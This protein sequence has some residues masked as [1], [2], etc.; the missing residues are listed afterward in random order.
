MITV[1]VSAVA[2]LP[3]PSNAVPLPGYLDFCVSG[4]GKLYHA[5]ATLVINVNGSSFSVPAN[6]GSGGCMR[7]IHTH[8]VDGELHIEPDE[9]KGRDYTLGDFFL[10]WGNW[11]N[12]AVRAT[13]NGTQ[14]FGGR[15]DASH[16][17]TVT[18]NDSVDPRPDPENI[19]L[20]K[21]GGSP[22][23]IVITYGPAAA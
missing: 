19:T 7:V 1:I 5:H 8:A 2:F 6:V 23:N 4:V 18:I 22:F 14:I 16:S 17:L 10:I 12:N 15:V 11:E 21:T 20:P 3:R 9:D 13:F